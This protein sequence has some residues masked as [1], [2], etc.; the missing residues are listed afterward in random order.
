MTPRIQLLLRG[1]KKS[2]ISTAKPKLPMTLPIL[3]HLLHVLNLTSVNDAQLWAACCLAFWAFLRCGEFTVT[4]FDSFNPSIKLCLSSIKFFQ[5]NSMALRLS[6]SKT[7]PFRLGVVI[8]VPCLC[9]A[10]WC[11]PCAVRFI[12]FFVRAQ[13]VLFPSLYLYLCGHPDKF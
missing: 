1:I 9:T 2:S 7:D 10:S 11:A 3:I 12:C 5:N 4:S 13:Q 6:A 8:F